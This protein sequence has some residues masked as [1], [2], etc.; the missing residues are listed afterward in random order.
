MAGYATEYANLFSIQR[1]F[2]AAVYSLKLRFEFIVLN[3]L[4][5][6]VQGR[7]S[8]FDLSAKRSQDLHNNRCTITCQ[9]TTAG[10]HRR[11]RS[12]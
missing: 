6:I 7:S 2:K 3:A 1:V 8:A 10:R 5:D 9:T 4:V 12:L 11:R